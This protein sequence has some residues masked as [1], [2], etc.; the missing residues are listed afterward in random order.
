MKSIVYSII[1][2]F[3]FG[4]IAMGFTNK[5][6]AT[7]IITI[8]AADSN[9]TSVTLAQSAKII[10]ARLKDFNAGKYSV[11]IIPAKHQIKVTL[12]DARDVKSIDSL[13]T[14]KGTIALYE[15]YSRKNVSSLPG[16]N[17][18]LFSLFKIARAKDTMGKIGCTPSAGVEKINDYL[19][20][21]TP[22][23]KY[24]FAWSQNFDTSE[25][26]LYALKITGD[27]GALITG[28]DIDSVMFSKDK[29]SDRNEIMI[30]L[31]KPAVALWAEATKRNIGNAIA[32]VLDN[33]V[34]SAPI[35]QS[36]IA[37]GHC[38]ITG[39]FTE[40]EAR[41]IAALGNNGV[42]PASFRILK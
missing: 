7:N 16:E 17:N 10:S 33:N 5:A 14:G 27:K 35:V 18:D 21:L 9:I 24:R 28:S 3:I 39:N 20:T 31:K 19:K 32:I 42:L 2:V 4:I 40:N 8:Q 11:T 26:C 15:T 38:Q 41:Y 25:V 34:I 37:G 22:D 30:N 12:D 36:V 29:K 13:L 23:K 1:A 6:N